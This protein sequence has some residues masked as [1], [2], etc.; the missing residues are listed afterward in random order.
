MKEGSET[1]A[2]L[3]TL[4][5]TGRIDRFIRILKQHAGADAAAEILQSIVG[6][7]ESCKF[8]ITIL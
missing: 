2:F 5:Q 3:E 1:E 4:P 6:G 8:K 7:A